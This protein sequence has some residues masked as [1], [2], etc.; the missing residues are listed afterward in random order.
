MIVTKTHLQPLNISLRD[1]HETWSFS[2][3][4]ERK[5]FLSFR[6]AIFISIEKN[7]KKLKQVRAFLR[8]E[9]EER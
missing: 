9:K 7:S 8:K 4:S 2:D 5:T 3:F 6:N 1:S